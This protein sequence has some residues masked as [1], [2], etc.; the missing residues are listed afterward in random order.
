M[1]TRGSPPPGWAEPPTQNKFLSGEVLLA[2]KKA[3]RAPLLE[4][5]YIEPPGAL[6]LFSKSEGV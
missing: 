6:T 1:P 2:R 3:D 5:P 4:V